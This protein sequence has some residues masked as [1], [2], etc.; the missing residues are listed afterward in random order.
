MNLRYIYYIEVPFE[1]LLFRGL[2]ELRLLNNLF[3]IIYIG[4]A[5]NDTRLLNL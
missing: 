2:Y 5:V 1:V 3:Y 4:S